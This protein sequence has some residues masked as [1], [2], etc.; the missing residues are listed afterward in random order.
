MPWNESTRMDEKHKFIEAFVSGVYHMS[1]LC[2]AAGISR[3]T[4]YFWV[5]RY[6]QYGWAGLEERSH[7]THRGS[8]HWRWR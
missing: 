2:R 7:A 6:Q 4:G 1:E 3:P 5:E 8:R